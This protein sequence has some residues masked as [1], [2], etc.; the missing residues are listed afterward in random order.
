MNAGLKSLLEWPTRLLGRPPGREGIAGA[1]SARLGWR[2]ISGPLFRKYVALFVAVVALALLSNGLLQI[3]FSY[4][5][6]TAA[7]VRIQREQADAA[8]A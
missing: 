5:E 6:Y 1:L 8:A 4:T 7:L 3:W 2:Q